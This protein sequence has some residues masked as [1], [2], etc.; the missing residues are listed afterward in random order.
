MSH[1]S[2]ADPPGQHTADVLAISVG[3]TRTGIGAF[4]D[5]RLHYSEAQSNHDEVGLLRAIAA[6]SRRLRPGQT[7][8]VLASVNPAVAALLIAEI[9]TGLG[10]GVHRIERDVPVPIRRQLAA[11]ARVGEDRLLNAA[12][13][14]A[15]LRQSCVIVDAGTAI[16]VDYVG[17]DGTFH[18]GAIGAGAQ[19]MLD[20]LHARAAQLPR[21]VMAA[22]RG[23]LGR[24]SAE[25]MRAAVFFGLRGLVSTLADEYAWAMGGRPL[26]VATGGDAE[27]LFSGHPRIDRIIAPLTLWGIALSW[28]AAAGVSL[29]NHQMDVSEMV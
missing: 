13:A 7:V 23:A 2:P 21:V 1:T 8:A 26:V 25:A 20:A 6:A 14:H 16:T 19:M 29:T 24:D 18:G 9:N 27:L 5:G 15:L 12:A 17:A 10:I 28:R 4:R 22:P 11:R 3:N